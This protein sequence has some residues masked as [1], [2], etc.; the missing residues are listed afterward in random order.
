MSGLETG[1]IGATAEIQG[2][3]IGRAADGILTAQVGRTLLVRAI[4]PPALRLQLQLR[5]CVPLFRTFVEGAG[6]V[7]IGADSAGQS[8][9]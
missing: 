4:D 9:G 1:E 7:Q 6:I 2:S 8:A 5:R 3:A